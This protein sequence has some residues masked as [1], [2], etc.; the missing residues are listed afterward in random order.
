MKSY[1]VL[2]TLIGGQR[3]RFERLTYRGRKKRTIDRVARDINARKTGWR[4]RLEH[5]M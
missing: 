5:S 4:S 1:A 3:A 2:S